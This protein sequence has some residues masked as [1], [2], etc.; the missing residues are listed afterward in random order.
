[1]LLVWK[2]TPRNLN[3]DCLYFFECNIELITLLL[4]EGIFLA[5]WFTFKQFGGCL[6]RFNFSNQPQPQDTGNVIFLVF[7]S[8]FVCLFVVVFL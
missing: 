8:V 7:T 6:Q 4:L 3:F 5:F 2:L 1:M